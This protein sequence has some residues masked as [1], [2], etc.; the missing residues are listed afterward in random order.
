MK[1][2]RGN[3]FKKEKFRNLAESKHS[4]VK[5]SFGMIFSIILIV[6]FL[7]VGFYVITKFLDLQKDIQIKQFTTNLQ[8]DVNDI[9][10]GHQGSQERTYSLAS[11]IKAVCFVNF[12]DS[13]KGDNSDIFSELEMYANPEDNLVFYPPEKAA[14]QISR[15][16]EN[17]NLNKI[18]SSENPFC[19]EN[20]KGKIELKIVMS[21]DEGLVRIEEI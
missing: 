8:E 20:S 17:I 12:S 19:I 18:T 15:T 16:I 6:I 7:V 10:R 14:G 1:I 9:W 11:G 3:S 4:Q 21:H 5:L 13:S 2:K